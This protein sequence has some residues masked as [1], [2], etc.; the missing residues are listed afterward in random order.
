M[1]TERRNKGVGLRIVV[2]N[3]E[4]TASEVVYRE[5]LGRQDRDIENILEKD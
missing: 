4:N 3:R 5:W 1:R 2:R